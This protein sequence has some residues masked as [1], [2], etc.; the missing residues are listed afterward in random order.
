[1][2]VT[3]GRIE[4]RVRPDGPGGNL[5]HAVR[6]AVHDP[7]W[8]LCRQWQL[9]EFQGEDA[10]TPVKAVMEVV[11]APLTRFQ[12]GERRP[13]NFDATANPI[14]PLVERERDPQAS[15]R[16]RADAGQR[17]LDSLRHS[18]GRPVS[19]S[20][21]KRLLDKYKL[22]LDPSSGD[23][24][25]AAFFALVGGRVPDGVA[26]FKG[27]AIG[28]L[29][30]VAAIAAIKD[31]WTAWMKRE[32]LHPAGLCWTE[33]R[34]DYRF[35]VS[36]QVDG[37]EIVLRSTDYAGGGLDWYHLD[38]DRRTT[39]RLGARAGGQT[40]TARRAVIPNPVSY[41]G[42]PSD[43]FWE[44]EDSR[45]NLP[46]IPAGPID[47][48]RLLLVEFAVSYGNDWWTI[49]VDV[50]YGHLAKIQSLE[51]VDTFGEPRS[52]P[53]APTDGWRMFEIAPLVAGADQED[54]ATAGELPIL[55]LLPVVAE[56]QR[57]EP[58]EDV[59][60]FRDELANMAWAVEHAVENAR[61][62][63]RRLSPPA[64]DDSWPLEALP[65]PSL[66]YVLVSSVPE[67]WF[68]LVPIRERKPTEAQTDL[69]QRILLRRGR[70]A[71]FD[72]DGELLPQAVALGR[73]LDRR[74]KR[75]VF[76]DEE[77]PRSGRRLHRMWV[78][79]R[80]MDG[81][82]IHW[83]SRRATA[84]RGE[85]LSLLRFDGAETLPTKPRG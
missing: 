15:L 18:S 53:P 78:H 83:S 63:P 3:W 81:R 22:E 7:L 40:R 13:V 11:S 9:G 80:W 58:V 85:G 66:H 42:M 57:G 1:M 72:A 14:E 12:A 65:F 36:G 71:R 68:P 10:G 70:I 48:A 27:L 30:D 50:A 31:E 2:S 16:Q 20:L 35:A 21:R 41:P 45:V 44:M 67:N 55:A 34:L 60:L 38:R 28:E 24:D 32:V 23:A 52:V 49:P 33:D 4:P 6:A 5:A 73:F 46:G 37:Q 54:A 79:T 59:L 77:V 75:V 74:Q 61:G 62:R 17:F 47:L 19:A 25:A 82:F 8:L 64:I 26:I 84:G 39:A 56:A 29:D 43:R 51:I 69:S 76:P